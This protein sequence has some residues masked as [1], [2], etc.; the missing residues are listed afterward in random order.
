M[1]KQY[2]F[3]TLFCMCMQCIHT[4]WSWIS[5]NS[6]WTFHSLRT[7][8]SRWTWRRLGSEECSPQSS[9]I[10][11]QPLN[12]PPSPPSSI[13]PYL[14]SVLTSWSMV[15]SRTH[16][17]LNSLFSIRT[18]G[19][20]WSHG[21]YGSLVAITTWYSSECELKFSDIVSLKCGLR[22]SQLKALSE[23][24]KKKLRMQIHDL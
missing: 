4:W 13:F 3:S 21:A 9:V 16:W 15:S 2:L 17:S 6:S 24:D 11:S 19:S 23:E 1:Y 10:V 12:Y 20:L 22:E 8:W 7:T 5:P 18:S 14:F